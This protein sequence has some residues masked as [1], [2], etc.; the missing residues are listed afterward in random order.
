MAVKE[1]KMKIPEPKE[2]LLEIKQ[3][4]LKYYLERQQNNLKGDYLE[5]WLNAEK[6][7]KKKYGID[8]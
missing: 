3:L 6:E 1:E 7:I 8:K 4:T 5:D 2:I